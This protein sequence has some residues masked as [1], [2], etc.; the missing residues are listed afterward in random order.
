M[1]PPLPCP[2]RHPLFHTESK[3]TMACVWGVAFYSWAGFIMVPLLRCSNI[4]LRVQD[5][6]AEFLSIHPF[7]EVDSTCNLSI[8]AFVVLSQLCMIVACVRS[9]I[10]NI[11]P[12]T[13]SLKKK[14][15]ARESVTYNSC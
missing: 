2:A 12:E 9:E 13:N 10:L 15:K 1:P 14:K 8:I 4:C 5:K 7:S 3:K 6:V 11:Y